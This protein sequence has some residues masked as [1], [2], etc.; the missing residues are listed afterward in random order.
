MKF[1]F[2]RLVSTS[3]TS[4]DIDDI[5]VAALEGGITYWCDN[6]K[7]V[8]VAFG[9]YASDQIA[10]GGSLQLFDAESN[11][12]YLLNRSKLI[13]GVKLWLESGACEDDVVIDGALNTSAID[14]ECADAIIQ[15][16][17][18]GEIMYS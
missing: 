6:V 7:I 15:F 13:Y 18:F 4:E 10:R 17:L 9:K 11:K 12:E 3:I 16:A 1:T 2:K 14:A 8:G 5:M